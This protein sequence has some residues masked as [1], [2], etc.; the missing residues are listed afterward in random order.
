MSLTA[1]DNY[2]ILRVFIYSIVSQKP[3]APTKYFS[4]VVGNGLTSP[5][6]KAHIGRVMTGFDM[7]LSLLTDAGPFQAHMHHL[8][9]Q[10]ANMG[11]PAEYFDVS[12]RRLTCT[13]MYVHVY[14]C[15]IAHYMYMYK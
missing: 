9:E 5:E 1:A 2:S 12:S 13:Y 7:A 6:F 8:Q 10:H 4:R 14:A 15:K 11:I 3:E